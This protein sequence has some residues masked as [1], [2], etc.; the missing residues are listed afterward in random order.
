[1]ENNVIGSSDFN[2]IVLYGNSTGI[3]IMGNKIG[4]DVNG[5]PLPNL[6]SG[7]VV[8]D[9]CSGIQIGGTTLASENVVANHTY[10]GIVIADT[11]YDCN[12]ARNAMYCNGFGIYVEAGSNNDVAFPAIE[13]I[14]SP[15]QITGACPS[16]AEI[17]VY[18]SNGNCT[19]CEG[20][21]YVGSVTSTGTTWSLNLPMPLSIGDKITATATVSGNTSQF[22]WCQEYVCPDNLAINAIPIPSGTYIADQEITSLGTVQNGANV[23]FKAGNSIVLQS[24]FEVQLGGLFEVLIQGCIP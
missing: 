8:V 5:T 11:S 14:V 21:H 10:T 12:L 20:F 15:L 18:K 16:N 4:A 3:Q 13:N 19:A 17:S 9:G 2:V 6:S 22:A 1:L 23:I 24:G 7:I